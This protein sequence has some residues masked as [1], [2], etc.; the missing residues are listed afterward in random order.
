MTR[1]HFF[2]T[3]LR[4]PDQGESRDDYCDAELIDSVMHVDCLRTTR[5]G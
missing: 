4:L 1:D 2:E 3:G 5:A